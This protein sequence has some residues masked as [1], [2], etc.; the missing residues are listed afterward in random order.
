LC[1]EEVTDVKISLWKYTRKSSLR[2][3]VWYNFVRINVGT[4][5]KLIAIIIIINNNN[6]I[7]SS[8]ELVITPFLMLWFQPI[9]ATHL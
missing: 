4:S 1:L 2:S 8:I 7:I 3:G 6:K 5:K 9:K